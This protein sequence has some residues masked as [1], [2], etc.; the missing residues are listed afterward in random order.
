A[1]RT[2]K[3][4]RSADSFI[5]EPETLTPRAINTLASA[6]IPAPPIPIRWTGPSSETIDRLRSGTTSLG[7][8]KDPRCHLIG[9]V[10][11][12]DGPRRPRHAL[13]A[14]TI[15]QHLLEDGT[16]RLRR[17]LRVFDDLRRAGTDQHARVRILL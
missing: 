2:R 5:S 7:E 12:R 6:L 14:R 17:R 1:P 10:R 9:S 16:E 13:A 15:G 4:A 8:R 3:E 11:T